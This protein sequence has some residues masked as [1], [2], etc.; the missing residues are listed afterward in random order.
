MVASGGDV[1]SL[2]L[3]IPFCRSKCTYCNFASGVYPASEHA[4]YVDRLIEDMQTAGRWAARM[5]VELPRRVDTVYLGGGT[6]SLLAPEL[7]QRLF[8]AMRSHFDLDPDAEVTV[9]CAPGQLSDATLVVLVAAGVNRVSLGVQSFI[10]REAASSGRLHNRAVALADV[11]RLRAAR[12]CNLNIDLIAGL[13]GQTFASWK[14]SL[15]VMT[16]LADAGVPHASVY[17]LEVDEDSRLGREVLAHGARYHADLVPT[18][19]AIAQMYEQAIETLG[20]AGLEQYEISNFCRSGFPSRHNLRYWQRR[21]YLGLGLDASSML[22][23]A[24]LAKP[25]RILRSTTTDD[26]KAYLEG[27]EPVET[28]WLTRAQQHEEAWFLGLRLNA[29]V[30]VAAVQQEFGAAMVEP[31]L[32]VVARLAENG[33]LTSDGKTVRLTAQGRL[34]S[35][36]V[37]QEF[38]GLGTE[39]SRVTG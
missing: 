10:D 12:I 38:L 19:D 37:F 8:A 16:S 22:H 23:E 15:S 20:E 3:S 29:G 30:D 4:R 24:D 11:M 26:L 32:K 31:A 34:L 33:L 17:M 39:T 13:P 36:D 9:E 25:A 18:D 35:N 2:Y 27:A 21:P 1:L 5:G 14:E 7:L 28:T 6:P